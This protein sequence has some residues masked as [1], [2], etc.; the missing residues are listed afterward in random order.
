MTTEIYLIAPEDADAATL[1]R[2]LSTVL[3]TASVAA[4]L[5]PRG[6]RSERD[7][8]DLVKALRPA[9]QDAGAA[10]LVEGEPGIVRLL[11]ADGLHVTGGIGAV[12]AAIE[13]LKPDFIVGAGDIRTRDDAMRKGEAGVDYILLGPLSGP[14]SPAQRDLAQWWAETMEIPGVL[15]DPEASAQSFD[16]GAC[17]FIGLPLTTAEVAK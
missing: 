6:A 14:I 7:Y 3:K 17:E 5:V 10:L 12:K 2:A 1:S 11:G 16:A 13:A 4:L 8:K 15:S 9:A